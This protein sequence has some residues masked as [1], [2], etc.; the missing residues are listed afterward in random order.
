MSH[1][2]MLSKAYYLTEIKSAISRIKKNRA[3]VKKTLDEIIRESATPASNTGKSS[4]SADV[5]CATFLQDANFL[6]YFTII[7]SNLPFRYPIAA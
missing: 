5:M 6:F 7:F 1:S 3:S 2:Y 4:Y